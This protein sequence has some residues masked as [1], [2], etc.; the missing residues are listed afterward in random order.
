MSE[1]S[2]SVVCIISSPMRGE[3]CP[4]D[5]VPDPA[6][7]RRIMGDGVAII[8]DDPTVVSPKDGHIISVF[9]TKH[10]I[11]FQNEDNIRILLHV[12]VGSMRLQG[13]GFEAHVD[14]G[15]K[16]EKGDKLLSLNLD[17]IKKNAD[18]LASPVIVTSPRNKYQV[19]VLAE[20]HIEV[21]DPLFELVVPSGNKE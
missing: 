8:P 2:D 4:L 18:A 11:V 5:E 7:S 12:G 17:Y 1:V 3:V 14:N 13:E 20:G 10:A 21:G 6:F 15:Q 9:H 16:V 19:K